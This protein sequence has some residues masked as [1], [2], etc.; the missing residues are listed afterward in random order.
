MGKALQDSLSAMEDYIFGKENIKGIKR[1]D[2]TLNSY[3]FGM[4]RYLGT[5]D[6]APNQ[7]AQRAMQFAKEKMSAML[8]NLNRLMANEFA[9]YREKVEAAQFS[10]FKEMPPVKM[11]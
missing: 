3:V 7:G 4:F 9:A 5:S 6:G 8:E 2:E 11:E 1:S 10:L